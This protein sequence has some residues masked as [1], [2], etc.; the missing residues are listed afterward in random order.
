MWIL[1]IFVLQSLRKKCISAFF[2]PFSCFLVACYATLHPALSVRPLV[3][4]S[5]SSW[6]PTK[7][8][9]PYYTSGLIIVSSVLLVLVL[10]K[11]RGREGC[12]PLSASIAW[13]D[14]QIIPILR[15]HL[16]CWYSYVQLRFFSSS[17]PTSPTLFGVRSEARFVTSVLRPNSQAKTTN[18]PRLDGNQFTSQTRQMDAIACQSIN[19]V[20]NLANQS[21]WLLALQMDNKVC[22]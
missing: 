12:C 17:L 11:K 5:I 16:P 15:H 6:G 18:A 2:R 22:N 1:A 3:S 9:P 20:E 13:F 4:L 19:V 7:I 8:W 21:T 10:I 14:M